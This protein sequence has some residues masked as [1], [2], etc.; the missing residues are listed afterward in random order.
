MDK[1]DWTAEQQVWQRVRANRE[2]APRDDLRQ[3]RREA[4]ELAAI[5]RNLASRLSG[6]QQELVKRLHG[7]EQANGA[8]LAG[9]GIMSRQNAEQLKLWQPEK[10]D[11]KKQLERCYHRTRRCMTEYLARSAEGEFGVVFD[12]LARREGEHCE[13]LARLLGSL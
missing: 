7:G 13:L 3:L 4:M 6:S 10:E 2:A 12:R 8:A 9:I 11:V 1:Q 5:Y